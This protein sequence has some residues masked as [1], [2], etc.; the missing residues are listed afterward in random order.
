[1]ATDPDRWLMTLDQLGRPL[2]ANGQHKRHP[3]AATKDRAQWRDATIWLARQQRI[4]TLERIKVTAQA[5]YRTRQSPSDTDACAPTVK[6]CIDGLVIA[7]VI[8]DDSHEYVTEVRY[9]APLIGTRLPDALL[10]TVEAA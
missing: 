1:M 5:R 10:L 2:T 3:M 6:G 8:R 4:P 7:G 9:L